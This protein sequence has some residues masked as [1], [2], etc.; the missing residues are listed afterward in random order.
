MH[1]EFLPPKQPLCYQVEIKSFDETAEIPENVLRYKS[2]I[3]RKKETFKGYVVNIKRLEISLNNQVDQDP[4][5]KILFITA[6]ILHDLDVEIS[7]HGDILKVLNIKQI[8]EQWKEICYKIEHTY[9]GDIVEPLMQAMNKTVADDD[10]FIESLYQDTFLG[11]Y[12]QIIFGEYS[13]N[14]IMEMQI[15]IYGFF[16]NTPMKVQIQAVLKEEEKDT[17]KI[18][19]KMNLKK[20]DELILQEQMKRKFGEEGHLKTEMKAFYTI[21]AEQEYINSINLIFS[22]YWNERMVKKMQVDVE[23]LNL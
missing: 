8:R 23:N 3:T 13:K 7:W 5:I 12:F 10:L 19:V 16:G 11:Y 2:V 18:A 20:E 1:V 4:F 14:K 6:K 21:L 22:M 17:A 9:T 15:P